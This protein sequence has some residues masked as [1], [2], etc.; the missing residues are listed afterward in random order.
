M[1]KK[2][3]IEEARKHNLGLV[4]WTDGLKLDQGH[5]VAIVCWEEKSNAKRKEMAFFEGKTKR[6]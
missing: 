6:Y 3:A 5:V 2:E 4:L 1:C